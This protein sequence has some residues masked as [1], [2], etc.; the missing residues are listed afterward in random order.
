MSWTVDRIEG[1]QAVIRSADATFNV[2][3]SALPDG[4][5]EGDIL[6]VAIDVEGTRAA[7]AAAEARIQALAQDDDGQDFSL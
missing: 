2:P 6:T 1:D 5:D 4:I 7:R 3:V